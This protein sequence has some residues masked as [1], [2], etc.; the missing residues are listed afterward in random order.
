MKGHA[1]DEPESLQFHCLLFLDVRE[2]SEIPNGENVRGES[3]HGEYESRTDRQCEH[4]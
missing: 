1:L 4:L 3:G 2:P